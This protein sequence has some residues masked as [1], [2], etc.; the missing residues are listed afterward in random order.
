M[1]IIV[2][3]DC[4][5]ILDSRGFP[6]VEVDC[7]LDD[8]SFGRAAVPSGASTGAAE[9][10]ELRDGAAAW[11]GKGVEQALENVRGEICSALIGEEAFEQAGIDRT[12]IALDGTENKSRLGA[13]AILGVSMAVCR[14]AAE[15]SELP[16]YRYLGGAGNLRLPIPLLNVVNGGAHANNNLDTQEFMIAPWGA[17]DFP[18]ALRMGVEVYHALRRRLM[19]QGLSVAVGDEGGFAPDLPGDE[20]VLEELS[21]AV[22]DAGYS[23]GKG[24][25]FAF[26]LDVAAS[27]LFRDGAYHLTTEKQPQSSQ[28][29]I[30]RYHG[31]VERFPITSIEDGLAEEDWKGWHDLTASLVG[32]RLIA[33]DLLVTQTTRLRRAIEERAANA[34]LIKLNQVGTV[35]ETLETCRLA[36]DHGFRVVISHRSGETEDDFIADLAVATGCG[37]IKTGAPCRSERN[38]KYN[39][40]LR[41]AEQLGSDA[42]YGPLRW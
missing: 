36:S 20:A 34:I 17:S 39:R 30:E 9:A 24:H 2:D 26:A 15:A 37:W 29:L 6:T 8:G 33:D 11:G 38:A 41:I 10:L 18:T 35:T 13:N 5:T 21:R 16:L 31:L 27:E 40:L 4:R 42:E 12:L 1:G 23:S 32:I 28:Q 19:D 7:L 22:E 3:L 14:A 25:E